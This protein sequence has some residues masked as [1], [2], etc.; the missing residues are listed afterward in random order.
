M[1][2]A[3]HRLIK[4]IRPAS[5]LALIGIL[6]LPVVS[7]GETAPRSAADSSETLA[8]ALDRMRERSL[9]RTPPELMKIGE[10]QRQVLRESGILE[11]ALQVGDTAPPFSLKN[12]VG[13]T[14]DSRKLLAAGPLIV[15]FYRGGWCP[16]CNVQ[17]TYMQAS[18]PQIA[19]AGASF[20]AI[21]PE[22]PDASLTVREK[23]ELEFEVLSD[24]GSAVADS[25]GVVYT[26]TRALDSVVTVFGLDLRSRQEVDQPRLPLA[27]TYVLD[28]AGVVRYAYLDVDYTRR[29][30][31]AEVLAVLRRL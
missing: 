25:F 7:A 18:L 3:A 5:I 27:A 16:Y 15:T 30:E 31:P 12:A 10:D 17:L 1:I 29:A 28:T 11:S 20:V 8:A 6:W 22:T 13:Q 24:P 19:A 2:A 23:L 21:S 14:V 9:A 26:P 4:Q